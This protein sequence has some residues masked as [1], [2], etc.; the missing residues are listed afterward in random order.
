VLKKSISIRVLNEEEMLANTDIKYWRSTKG[1]VYIP[2]STNSYG[3]DSFLITDTVKNSL[4][5]AVK[6]RCIPCS[7]YTDTTMSFLSQPLVVIKSSDLL[8]WSLVN[9]LG[10]HSAI[11]WFISV[12]SVVCKS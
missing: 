5:Y 10:F 9:L 8:T 12:V 1:I 2:I 3:G 6:V 7:G 11:F 4:A